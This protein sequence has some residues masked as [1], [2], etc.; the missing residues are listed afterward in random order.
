MYEKILASTILN[1]VLIGQFDEA[2]KTE[3]ADGM[4]AASGELF[5]QLVG[6]PA[7]DMKISA[8][9]KISGLTE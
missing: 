6:V 5:E 2:G 4:R 8:D 1:A 3:D 7:A 9:G